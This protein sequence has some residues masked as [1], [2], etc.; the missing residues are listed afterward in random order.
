MFQ[1]RAFYPPR[2]AIPSCRRRESLLS[3]PPAAARDRLRCSQGLSIHLE[4]REIRFAAYQGSGFSWAVKLPLT[5][6]IPSDR[7][8]ANA[9]RGPQQAWFWL[10][11]VG[12]KRSRG[13]ARMCL[14]PMPHQGVL[15]RICVAQRP[16]AGKGNAFPMFRHLSFRS[17]PI[18]ANLRRL[19]SASSDVPLPRV[20]MSRSFLCVPR[21][22][23]W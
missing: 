23:L 5:L 14:F 4:S 17:A 20:Q 19:V 9:T 12:L 18:S 16:S 22:P 6:V 21:R 11:G 15:T 10:A 13:I 1:S 2:L 7:E 8:G 3:Q